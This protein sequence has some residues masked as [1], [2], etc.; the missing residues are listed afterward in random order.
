MRV[1]R[2]TLLIVWA[3]TAGPAAALTEAD[4]RAK[5]YGALECLFQ[6]RCVIGQPCTRTWRD[7]RWMINDATASAYQVR[8]AGAVGR[9]LMLMQDARWKGRSEARAILSPMREAVA[10]HLTVFDGGQA[11]YALQYAGT[12]GSGQMLRGQCEFK[13]A[14]E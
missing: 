10:S 7:M 4:L 1:T 14:T 6:E 12:P 9:K 8:R 5:G 2:L 3:I 13:E 11:I